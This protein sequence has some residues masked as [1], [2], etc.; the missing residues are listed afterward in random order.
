ML[1][2]FYVIAVLS[3]PQRFKR[4]TQLFNEFCQRMKNYGVN[5]VTV[6]TAY[7]ER[8]FET[9]ATIKLRTNSMLWHKEN[10]IN[11]AISKLPSDWKYV[12]WIDSDVDFV[13]PDWAEE[14]VHMLQQYPVVQMFQNAVDLGPTGEIMSTFTSFAYSHTLGKEYPYS[15]T[16]KPMYY[17]GQNKKSYEWHT[18]YAWAARRDAIDAI[19]GLVDWAVVGSGDC[20]MACALTGQASKSTSDSANQHYNKL[21]YEYEER[22]VRALH[23]NIGYVKGTLYHYWHGKKA[24]RGYVDRWSIIVN[25]Q[26]DPTR[27]VHKDSQGLYALYPGHEDLRTALF[28][29]FESRNED[30]VDTA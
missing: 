7:G 2:N 17:G 22:A 19:G 4:R 16:K 13:R 25:T 27:H 14:T 8:P 26:Y 21:L 11:I 20:H 18:G 12:A 3:N 30:S 10:M 28:Q 6:E 9:D 15:K 23:K 29:Y 1:E 5:L 24:D